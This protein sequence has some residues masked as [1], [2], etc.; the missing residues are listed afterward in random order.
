MFMPDS[1]LPRRSMMA[2]ATAALMGARVGL[3]RI[4]R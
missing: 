1:I 4:L 3:R 2:A